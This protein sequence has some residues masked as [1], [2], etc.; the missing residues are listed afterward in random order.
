MFAVFSPHEYVEKPR[1]EPRRIKRIGE[2]GRIAYYADSVSHLPTET[3]LAMGKLTSFIS[4]SLEGFFEGPDNDLSWQTDD[5]ESRQF[6]IE[7]LRRGNTLLFGRITYELFAR[8]WQSPHAREK[9]AVLTDLMNRAQKIVCSRT[10]TAANWQH[11]RLITDRIGDEISRLKNESSTDITILG[12]ATLLAHLI[13]LGLV[14]EYH[15]LMHP[16]YIF[17]GRKPYSLPG[18]RQNLRLLNSHAFTNGTVLMEY[19]PIETVAYDD[20]L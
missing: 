10:L 7:R 19:Q 20:P 12:S 2:V 3:L 11:T 5:E 16:I 4:I 14:D 18:K 6:A 1:C 15:V 8:Y 17:S 9:D 13:E